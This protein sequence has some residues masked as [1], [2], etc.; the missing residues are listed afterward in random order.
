MRP[1]PKGTTVFF[2]KKTPDQT[3]LDEA[4]DDLYSDLKGRDA[5]S[6]EYG[7]VAEQLKKLTELKASLTAKSKV[8]A[9]TVALIAANLIGIILILHYEKVNVVT[10]KALSFVGKL[11]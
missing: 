10:S 4:I 8:D 2:L 6:K 3:Q 7:V 11:R 5:H 1:L 9:N